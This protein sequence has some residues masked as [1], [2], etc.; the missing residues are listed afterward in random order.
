[1]SCVALVDSNVVIAAVAEA[2]EHHPASLAL[3][4]RQDLAVAAHSYA[5]A[6]STLTRRGERAPFAFAPPEAWAAL[7]SVRAVTAILGLTPAQTFDAVRDY[8][9]AGGVGARLY[10]KLIGEVAALNEIPIIVTWN[11][12]HLKSLFPDLEVVTPAAF[13]SEV[14]RG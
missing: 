2:H 12:A 14:S 4:D 7:Q 1:L 8:A 6:Y 3:F 13:Q 9:R 10:D 5:E 11:T